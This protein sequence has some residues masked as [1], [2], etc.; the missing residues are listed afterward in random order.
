M[1]DIAFLERLE[2]IIAE[3]IQDSPENSYTARLAASG[4]LAAAQK[5]GEE[6]VEA[7]LAATAQSDDELTNEAADLLFHLLVVLSMRG[8]PLAAVVA[9]LVQRHERSTLK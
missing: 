2:Q 3:R 6:G 7:A 4:I 8:I 9:T 1:S 5:L